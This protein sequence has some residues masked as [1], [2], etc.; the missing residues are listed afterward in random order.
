M[1]GLVGD[2]CAQAVRTIFCTNGVGVIR[3]GV[4]TK[5]TPAGLVADREP[6]H[7]AHVIIRP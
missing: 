1:T 6:Q 7:I 2:L 5:L 3:L 4:R